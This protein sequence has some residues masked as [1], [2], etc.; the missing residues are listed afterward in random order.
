[1]LAAAC[2]RSLQVPDAFGIRTGFEVM[3][4]K[5]DEKGSA[6]IS[7]YFREGDQGVVFTLSRK[8]DC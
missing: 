4:E 3:G 2:R 6:H 8:T 7:S 5:S 1:M